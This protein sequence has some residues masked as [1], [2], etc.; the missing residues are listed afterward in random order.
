[1]ELVKEE[2]ALKQFI[3][4][5]LQGI[6]KVDLKSYNFSIDPDMTHKSVL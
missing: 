1:M 3:D 5:V 6:D 4:E 2:D